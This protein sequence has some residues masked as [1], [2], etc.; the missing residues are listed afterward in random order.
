MM[1]PADTLHD[2]LGAR[3][4]RRAKAHDSELEAQAPPT[5]KRLTSFRTNV[6][7]VVA[8]QARD[9]KK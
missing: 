7:R 8:G 3:A 2:L 4:D 5:R 6:R 9:V 1:P